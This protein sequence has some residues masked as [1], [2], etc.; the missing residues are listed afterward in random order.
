MCTSV[1]LLAW[2]RNVL[3]KEIL[4]LSLLEKQFFTSC[5]LFQ[6]MN[7]I[8][9][10]WKCTE[11]YTLTCKWAFIP[12]GRTSSKCVMWTLG[13]QLHLYC[14]TDLLQ[15]Y[16][17]ACW[18]RYNLNW[19]HLD[20]E[21]WYLSIISG[22]CRCH[23]CSLLNSVWPDAHCFSYPCSFVTTVTFTEINLSLKELLVKMQLPR[24]LLTSS[25]T[26]SNTFISQ[27]RL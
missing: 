2:I 1:T 22:G 5:A 18:H 9:F 26:C 11:K 13:S 7:W 4:Q 6:W 19:L 14:L 16:S 17:P 21:M 10:G 23:D 12:G 25:F 20:S 8:P 3:L 15:L 24:M 27:L